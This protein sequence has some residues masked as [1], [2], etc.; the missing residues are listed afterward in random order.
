MD[1]TYSIIKSGAY[2][3]LPTF[4]VTEQGLEKQIHHTN[5]KGAYTVRRSL[6]FHCDGNKGI[7]DS[8]IMH[9]FI[10]AD[11]ITEYQGNTILSYSNSQSKKD[12]QNVIEATIKLGQMQILIWG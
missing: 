5:E 6:S 10:D 1:T 12:Y 7:E 2:Y 11:T 4:S 8:M 3:K 9:I